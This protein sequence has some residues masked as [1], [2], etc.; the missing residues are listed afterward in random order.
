MRHPSLRQSFHRLYLWFVL[1]CT[2]CNAD[3]QCGLMLWTAGVCIGLQ[4]RVQRLSLVV[5]QCKVLAGVF[6]SVGFC[7]Q[8]DMPIYSASSAARPAA[9][10]LRSNGSFW[11]FQQVPQNSTL[12]MGERRLVMMVVV[13][14]GA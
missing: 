8:S 4:R 11:P 7:Q 14:P 5:E 9:R 10:Y 3:A 6:T 2:R 12:C 1:L 13:F